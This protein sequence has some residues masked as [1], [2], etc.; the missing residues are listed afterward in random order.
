MQVTVEES[1]NLERKLRI[2]VPAETIEKEITERLQKVGRN[3]KIKGFRPGKVPPKVLRQHYGASVRREVVG[4]MMQN[5]YLQAVREQEMNP[6]GGPQFDPEPL[7]TGK[8]LAY[9]ATF[10][11]YPDIALGNIDK[12]PVTRKDTKVTDG[13]IDD[14]IQKLREQR[15]T[16]V[17]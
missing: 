2:Q 11:I 17:D 6:A 7:E 13:D 8:D 15:S 12:L 9:T 16:F 10:E 14:M 1:N 4:E 5:S 3:V